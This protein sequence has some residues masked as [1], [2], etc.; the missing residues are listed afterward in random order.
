MARLIVIAGTDQS[1]RGE[2]NAGLLLMPLAQLAIAASID[3]S[4]KQN[5]SGTKIH[6]AHKVFAV[7][8]IE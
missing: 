7:G 5:S 8:Q 4:K 3:P 2:K 1:R 6:L